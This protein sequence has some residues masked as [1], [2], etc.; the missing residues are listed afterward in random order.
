MVALCK[1]GAQRANGLGLFA[2]GAAL[3]RLAVERDAICEDAWRQLMLAL[4]FSGNRGEALTAYAELRTAMADY[5]GDEPGQESQ[6]LFLT[7]LRDSVEHVQQAE[8]ADRAPRLRTLLRLLRQE[9]EC[10]PGVSTPALDAN[11]SA[12]AVRVLATASP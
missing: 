9:L 7:I 5:L 10:T 3:A 2:T 12:V 11:L 1:R 6:E 4:W 8:T